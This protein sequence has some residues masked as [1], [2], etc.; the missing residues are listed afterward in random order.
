M[1][2]KRVMNESYV[3]PHSEDAISTYRRLANLKEDVEVQ[4]IDEWALNEAAIQHGVQ[5]SDL[6]HMVLGEDVSLDAASRAL[7]A[8]KEIVRSKSDIE[9]ALEELLDSAEVNHDTG[10]FDF[11]SLLI[12]GEMGIG[13]TSI[14]SQWCKKHGFNFFKYDI[15]QASPESFEGVIANDPDELK[16]AM[17]KISRELLIPL[18]KPNNIFFIDEYNRGRTDIR[19]KLLDLILNHKLAVPMIAD[20]FETSAK[21]YEKYGQLQEDGSL[22]FPNL[23]FVVCAQNPYGTRYGGTHELDAAE[24]GRFRVRK[25]EVVNERVLQY[26]TAKF[27]DQIQKFTKLGKMYRVKQIKNKLAMAELLLRSPDFFFDT[28]TERDI[29]YDKYGNTGKNLDPRALDVV[30]SGSNGTL[31]NVLDRWDEY[32]NPRKKAMAENILKDFKEVDDVANGVLNDGTDSEVFK[33][34]MP[35]KDLLTRYLDD[36]SFELT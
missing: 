1:K 34:T 15:R 16:F 36:P 28:S 35:A 6:R 10:Y 32:C 29:I 13:K 8:Q 23:L 14:V 20:D 24:V 3:H 18:S 27:T 7:E 31:E 25:P 5:K 22:Y 19:Q 4:E 33:Q 2:F 26:L 11:E 21:F 17:R 30:L 9:E 12:E